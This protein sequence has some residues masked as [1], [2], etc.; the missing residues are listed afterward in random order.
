[1][2]K[3]SSSKTN[4]IFIILWIS[5][6]LTFV[7]GQILLAIVWPRIN[8]IF[9]GNATNAD[10]AIFSISLISFIAL[11]VLTSIFIYKFIKTK[12]FFTTDFVDN[13]NYE[14]SNINQQKVNN[15]NF[16]FWNQKHSLNQNNDIKQ[17]DMLNSNND[18]LNNE[19]IINNGMNNSNH[20]FY[21]DS[22]YN[23]EISGYHDVIEKQNPNFGVEYKNRSY[24]KPGQVLPKGYRF[25]E[26]LGKIVKDEEEIMPD[27]STSN[28]VSQP[29][30][31]LEEITTT[32]QI[33]EMKM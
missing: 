8:S 19:M 15:K 4:N 1:M 17:N 32:E 6:V 2:S 3:D 23:N 33:T 13:K 18:I 26:N 24:L 30:A 11:I 16:D 27:I 9:L 12:A 28:N 29:N 20:N 14:N 31:I 25:D 10:I 22:Y 21:S 5:I 7:L